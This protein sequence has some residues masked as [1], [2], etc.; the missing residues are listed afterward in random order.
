MDKRPEVNTAQDELL[1][2]Q[3]SLSQETKT[4]DRITVILFVVL[5][6]ALAALMIILPDREFSEQENRY[7]Q[8]Q[9]EFTIKN[10]ID[11][12]YTGKVGDY[13]ADQFPFRDAFVAIKGAAEIAQG[14]RENNSVTL[15]SDGYII[16]RGGYPDYETADK[17]LSGIIAFADGAGR[18]GIPYVVAIAGRGEDVLRDKQPA[19]YPRDIQDKAYEYLRDN[20]DSVENLSYLDLRAPFAADESGEQL[21]YKTDHH[22]T[23][24]GALMGAN[25]ILKELG[26]ETHDYSYYSPETASDAFYGTTWSSGGMKWVKPDTIEFFRFEGDEEFVTHI[27]DTGV[28]YKGFYD[29]AY[30][31]KK[32]KYSSFIGGNNAR[33]DIYKVDETGARVERPKLVLL[34]DSFAHSAAPFLAQ[35]YD[36]IYIDL[37]Y[38]KDSV[39]KLCKEEAVSAVAVLVN[40]DSLES[41]S[42]FGLLKMGL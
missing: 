7:L 6:F 33:V 17:N 5:I 12:S 2:L 28:E 3:R 20:L 14:K 38:Y 40:F 25:L 35:S 23:S 19:L 41:S 39:F 24:R 31:E 8:K 42:T 11:G 34:K 4:A 18:L 37:R 32:D 30:L 15:A 29:R 21:Y 13:F 36:L 16:K 27:D 22:W 9:P 10:L 1:N 26:A